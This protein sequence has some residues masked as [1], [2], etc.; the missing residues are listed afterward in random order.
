MLTTSS[1]MVVDLIT[2]ISLVSERYLRDDERSLS[3]CASPEAS[4][5]LVLMS[6][7]ALDEY[8]CGC[9]LPYR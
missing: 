6:T 1:M 3:T 9:D 8:S 4:F 2:Y 7:N 5:M